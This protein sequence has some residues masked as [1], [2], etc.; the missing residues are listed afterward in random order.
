MVEVMRD[1][2][3]DQLPLAATEL[4]PPLLMDSVIRETEMKA[5]VT[6]VGLGPG[7]Q[8]TLWLPTLP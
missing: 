7:G 1:L 5:Q 8:F 6:P 3:G 2:S 4:L